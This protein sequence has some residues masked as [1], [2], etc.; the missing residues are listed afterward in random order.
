MIVIVGPLIA[1]HDP[2]QSVAAAFLPPGG[3]FP[4]GTDAVGRDVLSRLLSYGWPLLVVPLIA[5]VLAAVAG[6]GIGLLLVARRGRGRQAV[7]VLDVFLVVPPI[8][9][10]I[11][12]GYVLPP[13][14]WTL[15]LIA[16]MINTPFTAR[17]VRTLADGYFDA[18]FVEVSLVEGE[19][20]VAIAISEILPNLWAP[21]LGELGNRFVIAL[22]ILVTAGF[23]GIASLGDG[24][25]WASMITDSLAGITVNPAAVI[26]PA[27][28]I[29]VLGVGVN[30]LADRWAARR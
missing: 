12:L 5:V 10:M 3:T 8:L 4:L 28:G 18:G 11:V 23:L 13:G 7:Q 19:R 30:L 14:I 16:V 29:G 15:I 21:L 27:V 9:S 20:R 17:F 2:Q 26:A 25:D 24:A 22:Y 6:V 1:Q